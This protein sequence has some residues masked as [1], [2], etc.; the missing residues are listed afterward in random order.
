VKSS[1]LGF[2]L[3]SVNDDFIRRTQNFVVSFFFA[4]DDINAHFTEFMNKTEKSL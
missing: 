3:F 2:V 4:S 1:P